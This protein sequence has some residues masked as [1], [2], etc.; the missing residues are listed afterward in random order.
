MHRIQRSPKRT[1]EFSFGWLAIHHDWLIWW[2]LINPHS[3]LFKI[4]WFMI[5]GMWN[6]LMHTI[7][8]VVHICRG[9]HLVG[10]GSSPAVSLW[11]LPTLKTLKPIK[12][13]VYMWANPILT[14]FRFQVIQ[15]LVYKSF[16]SKF[17][18]WDVFELW[19]TYEMIPHNIT[20]VELAKRGAPPKFA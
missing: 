18:T 2:H 10:H 3:I 20:S 16:Y 6:N 14:L 11:T 8:D 12:L 15:I 4:L 1:I 5:D 17:T 13:Q 7:L 19:F 9:P